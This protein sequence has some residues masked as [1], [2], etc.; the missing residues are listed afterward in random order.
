MPNW[1]GNQ[2]VMFNINPPLNPGDMY[3]L[4]LLGQDQAGNLLEYSPIL[5]TSGI[6]SNPPVVNGAWPKNASTGVSRNDTIGIAFSEAM[7]PDVGQHVFVEVN[8]TPYPTIERRLNPEYFVL[9]ISPREAWP[10]SAN[11]TVKVLGKVQDTAGNQMN[12]GAPDAPAYTL[13]FQTGTDAQAGL[14]V[15]PVLSSIGPQHNNTDVADGGYLTPMVFS[16]QDGASNPAFLQ[17][18]I[19][20]DDVAIVEKATGAPLKGYDVR[21]D[22]RDRLTLFSLGAFSGLAP[23]TDYSVVLKPSL[24]NT[25]GDQLTQTTIDFRTGRQGSNVAP[26]AVINWGQHID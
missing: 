2:A 20:W 16:F 9:N 14:A 18:T 22:F 25:Y 13:S 11:I 12:G 3:Q 19:S 24:R 8:G 21:F 23:D 6:E 10:S 1:Q 7:A 26:H 4:T 17:R 5:V 15:N